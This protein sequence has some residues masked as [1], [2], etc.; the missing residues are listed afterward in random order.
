MRRVGRFLL[1]VP[2]F[3]LDVAV[4][5]ASLPFALLVLPL[6]LVARMLRR[7]RMLALIADLAGG[8]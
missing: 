6:C 8:K 5:V 1:S 4:A 2:G 7:E 3:L